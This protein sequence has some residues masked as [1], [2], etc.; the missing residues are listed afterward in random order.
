MY[1]EA[2][3][4]YDLIHDARDRDANAE[5]E[6]VI[7]EIRLRNPQ[8]RTMLDVACGTGANLRRFSESF[9]VVGLD[10]S[11]EMLTIAREKYPH[12]RFVTADM[13]SFDL[14]QRFDAVVS[15][16]S[17]IGYLLEATDLRRAV[18]TMAGHLTPG[19]VL[20]LEGWVEPDKWI[21]SEVSVDAVETPGLALARVTCSIRDGLRT[22]LTSRYVA[23]TSAGLETIDE[24]HVMRL[25]D[26]QEFA[27][28]YQQAGLG[29]ER[30]AELLR[31]GRAVYVGIAASR[32]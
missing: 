19:G 10:A 25:S 3:A 2:A 29:F 18:A 23:A 14:V 1:A 28:A 24:H 15:I 8:A 17:G 11:E 27:S 7:D 30:L 21:D 4:F 32:H 12:V 9:E 22:E 31:P 6:L 20:M 16:F 26:P 5:A 13:R